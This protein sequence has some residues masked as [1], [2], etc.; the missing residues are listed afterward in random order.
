MRVHS[1][2]Q[3]S[4]IW[5]NS[6]SLKEEGRSCPPVGN[7]A[8]IHREQVAHVPQPRRYH[9]I[10]P[11]GSNCNL[12]PSPCNNHPLLSQA[13]PRY[14]LL[15]SSPWVFSSL[16]SSYCYSSL[17]DHEPNFTPWVCPPSWCIPTLLLWCV[18]PWSQLWLPSRPPTLPMVYQLTRSLILTCLYC[19]HSFNRGFKSLNLLFFLLKLIASIWFLFWRVALHFQCLSF[20]MPLRSELLFLF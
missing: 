1:F 10:S 6:F 13:F 3:P 15:S 14:A 2:V 4:A 20:P 16:L 8:E 11:L 12:L 9:D 5:C 19:L 18:L 7:F 17:L